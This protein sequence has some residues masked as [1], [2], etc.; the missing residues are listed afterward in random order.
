[1]DCAITTGDDGAAVV[2]LGKREAARAAMG[3]ARQA[4]PQQQH[5]Q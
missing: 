1:M 2:R 5:H 4:Q 3:A